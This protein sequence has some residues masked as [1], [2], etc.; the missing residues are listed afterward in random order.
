MSAEQLVYEVL[1]DTY[2]DLSAT[3]MLYQGIE[4]YVVETGLETALSKC[5]SNEKRR[6]VLQA[7]MSPLLLTDKQ[8]AVSYFETLPKRASFKA[9]SNEIRHYAE[10]KFR[11]RN[12]DCQ[13]SDTLSQRLSEFA[14]LF[15]SDKVLKKEM[16]AE[17]SDCLVELDFIAGRTDTISIRMKQICFN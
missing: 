12:V 5:L 13:V 10:E 6:K 17:I 15:F 9:L 1:R 16:E 11:S 8:Y 2:E 4:E 3:D 7:Y 14:V